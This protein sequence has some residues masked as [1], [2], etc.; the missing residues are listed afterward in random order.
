MKQWP[1]A[2]HLLVLGFYVAFSLLIPALIG[3]FWLGPKFG[4][5]ILFFLIGLGLGTII[6]VYG[7]YRMVKPFMEET[8]KEGQEE[9]LRRPAKI[10]SKVTSSKQKGNEEQE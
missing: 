9:Q 7:V 10:L 2:M 6:M 4:H 8:K 3:F 5:T 1:A